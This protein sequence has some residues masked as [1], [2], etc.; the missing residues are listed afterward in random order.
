MFLGIY[1]EKKMIWKDSWTPAFTATLFTI[2]MTWKQPKFLSTEE[3]IKTMWYIYTMEYYSV[4]KKNEI[5]TFRAPWRDLEIIISS[6]DISRYISSEDMIYHIKSDREGETLY[7]IPYTWNLKRNN[8][9]E[10]R[11]QKESH[12]IRERTY[13]CCG[14]R[15]GEGIVGEFGMDMYTLLY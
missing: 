2:A 9:N 15:V 10:L 7:S 3:W 5:M 8:T 14:A 4:I 1:L 13:S 6:E 11:K 12:R